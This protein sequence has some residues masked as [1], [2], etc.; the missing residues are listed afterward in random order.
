MKFFI[1]NIC[2]FLL[3]A[4]GISACQSTRCYS[5]YFH[6]K[7][8]DVFFLSDTS[9]INSIDTCIVIK[10]TLHIILSPPI[11]VKESNREYFRVYRKP[12]WRY[13][14]KIPISDYPYNLNYSFIIL[15]NYYCTRIFKRK[16][17]LNYSQDSSIIY[18]SH[19]NVP[20]KCRNSFSDF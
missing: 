15:E 16:K 3:V 1:N 6:D 9:L 14:E 10:D 5:L 19:L 13:T 8:S 18:S 2:A 17:G 12:Y 4:C 7:K 11:L 20:P